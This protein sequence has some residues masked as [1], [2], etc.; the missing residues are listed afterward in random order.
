MLFLYTLKKANT[1]TPRK[2]IFISWNRASNN[3]NKERATPCHV[4][5]Q[6]SSFI[7]KTSFLKSNGTTVEKLDRPV[8][9]NRNQENTSPSLKRTKRIPKRVPIVRKRNE[10]STHTRDLSPIFPSRPHMIPDGRNAALFYK[11]L[12]IFISGLVIIN[13]QI[14]D[15]HFGSSCSEEKSILK[16]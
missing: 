10:R 7:H 15:I 5:T 1:L 2:N 9:Y 16:T 8:T 4:H 3:I 14:L 13:N 6:S 11:I 12:D